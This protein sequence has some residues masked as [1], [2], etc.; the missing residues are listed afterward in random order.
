METDL[1]FKR[2]FGLL[3]EKRL[4]GVRIG[5]GRKVGGLVWKSKQKLTV[6]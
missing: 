1:C 4:L 3:N 6:L 5:A 2:S